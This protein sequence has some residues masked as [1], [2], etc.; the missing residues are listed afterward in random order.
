LTAFLY[1]TNA[2]EYFLPVLS[3]VYN[4]E[5]KNYAGFQLRDRAADGKLKVRQ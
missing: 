2:N 1:A 4:A 3:V 5:M